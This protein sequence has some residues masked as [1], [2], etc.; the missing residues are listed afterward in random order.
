MLRF[1]AEQSVFYAG[2][3]FILC[4]AFQKDRLLAAELLGNRS[5]APGIVAS[6]GKKQGQFR[7]PGDSKPFAM[8]HSLDRTTEPPAYFPFAFD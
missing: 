5:A 8:Y 6:M 3:D 4:G 1:L 7:T 2:D